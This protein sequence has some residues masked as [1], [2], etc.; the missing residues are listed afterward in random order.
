MVDIRD[1][2]LKTETSQSFNVLFQN[3]ISQSA[4]KYSLGQI[5]IVTNRYTTSKQRDGTAEINIK[6][7]EVAEIVPEVLKKA[8]TANMIVGE[9]VHKW[10]V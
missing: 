3:N 6:V 7:I 10:R 9:W 5:W 1:S 2:N 8:I 4:V